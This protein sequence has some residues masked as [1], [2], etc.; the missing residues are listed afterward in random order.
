[1]LF[2]F[3][4]QELFVQIN[5]INQ[6]SSSKEKSS[7]IFYADEQTSLK[8]TKKPQKACEFITVFPTPKQFH[9]LRKIFLF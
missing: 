5:V 2:N 3:L 6:N 9:D 8:S 1:M 7:P 4:K